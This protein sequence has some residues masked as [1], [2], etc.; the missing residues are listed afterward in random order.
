V[1][2][3]GCD[4]F[5]GA[6]ILYSSLFT[7]NCTR[8]PEAGDWEVRPDRK[9]SQECLKTLLLRIWQCADLAAS[10]LLDLRIQN[11]GTWPPAFAK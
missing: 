4:R 2:C 1:L 7:G 8:K 10:P 11:P 5:L 3:R 6:P 9:D